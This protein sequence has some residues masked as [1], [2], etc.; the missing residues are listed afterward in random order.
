MKQQL[1]LLVRNQLCQLV[2]KLL[3]DFEK[4]LEI[5]RSQRFRVFSRRHVEVFKNDG[6]VHVDDDEEGYE[7][8]NNKV[9]DSNWGAAA[10]AFPAYR[11][12]IVS[13]WIACFEFQNIKKISLAAK[14]TKNWST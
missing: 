2:V 13:I 9:S 10:V 11:I 1:K 4:L 8:E 3:P 14:E 6:D 12:S 7:H 5:I